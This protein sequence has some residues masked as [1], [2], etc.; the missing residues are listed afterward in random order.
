M[1]LNIMLKKSCAS[2]AE[3]DNVTSYGSINNAFEDYSTRTAKYQELTQLVNNMIKFL[4]E[5]DKIRKLRN[6][7]KETYLMPGTGYGRTER[8]DMVEEY[9]RQICECIK[10][11]QEFQQLDALCCEIEDE[12]DRVMYALIEAEMPNFD[13]SYD[14]STFVIAA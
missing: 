5:D 11:S 3:H 4:V 10:S 14:D 6:K 1:R 7:I 8:D 12:S 2:W 13:D 9:D